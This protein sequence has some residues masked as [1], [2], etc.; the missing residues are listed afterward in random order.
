MDTAGLVVV[1]LFIA[2]GLL[3]VVITAVPGLILVYGAVLVWAIV[4]RTTAAW[5]VLGIATV[6]LIAGETGKYILPGHRLREAGVPK[7]SMMIGGLAAI[8]G[9]FV[10]PVIGL[11]IGFP[12]GVYLSERQ[13]LGDHERAWPSTKSAMK[14]TGLSILIELTAALLVAGLWLVAVL[15]WT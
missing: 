12:L 3:G 5:I 1:G 4:E 9:F 6:L 7:R 8:V 10:I 14:A 13:R 2:A 15:F 11:F